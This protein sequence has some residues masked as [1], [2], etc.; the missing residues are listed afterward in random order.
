MSLNESELARAKALNLKLKHQAREFLEYRESK[1]GYWTSEAMLK[2][3][4]KDVNIAEFKYPKHDG[5]KH[6][7][8][9]DRSSCHAARADDALDVGKMIVKPGSKQRVMHDTIWNGKRQCM[10]FP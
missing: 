7:W 8:I 9:F 6:V 10:N 2:Q 3:L 1:E 5:W 4:E